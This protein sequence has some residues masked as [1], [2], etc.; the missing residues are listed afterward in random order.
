MSSSGTLSP[1]QQEGSYFEQWALCISSRSPILTAPLRVAW[2]WQKP[3]PRCKEVYS[4][5]LTRFKQLA[6]LLLQTTIIFSFTLQTRRHE[7][8]YKVTPLN[9]KNVKL[10]ALLHCLL[11]L[12]T[13]TP[14]QPK[15]KLL[16][17][18]VF[19]LILNENKNTGRGWCRIFIVVVFPALL[20][21]EKSE[22]SLAPR[23]TGRSDSRFKQ[24]AALW[25]WQTVYV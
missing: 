23:Q 15:W 12:R 7:Y 18:T 3:A 5:A 6:P 16:M 22:V 13:E 11:M 8:R 24:R 4:N 20:R 17:Q 19:V 1:R 21:K 25:S 14:Q 2:K 10:L 9:V